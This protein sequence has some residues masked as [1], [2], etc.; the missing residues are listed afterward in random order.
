MR[1]EFGEKESDRAT[2]NCEFSRLYFCWEN[3]LEAR[4]KNKKNNCGLIR[5]INCAQVDNA[6]LSWSGLC[7]WV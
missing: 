2:D 6:V 7:R 3:Y 1:R 5:K 4:P